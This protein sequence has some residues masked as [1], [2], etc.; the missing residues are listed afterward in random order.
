[1]PTDTTTR[2]DKARRVMATISSN[3]PRTHAVLRYA[4]R[5]PYSPPRET[6][7]L[8]ADHAETD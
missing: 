5:K 2:T 4:P 7:A 1:M 6:T 3:K 8:E